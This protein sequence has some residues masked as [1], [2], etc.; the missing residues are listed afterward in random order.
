[1]PRYVKDCFKTKEADPKCIKHNGSY[2][3][4]YSKCPVLFREKQNFKCPNKPNSF[5]PANFSTLT[6]TI[7]VPQTLDMNNKKQRNWKNSLAIANNDMNPRKTMT[8][9]DYDSCNERRRD[10]QL[11]DTNQSSNNKDTL[12]PSNLSKPDRNQRTTTDE[13]INTYV[14]IYTNLY[15]R[16][17]S[18]VNDSSKMNESFQWT[19]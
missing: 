6:L 11:W 9:D 18:F 4:I 1:M 10:N 8:S 19:N 15:G 2:T 14:F 17:G 13:F 3:T 7:T 12:T 16:D 5:I